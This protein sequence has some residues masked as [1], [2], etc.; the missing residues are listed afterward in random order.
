M[1]DT[2]SEVRAAFAQIPNAHVDEG[3]INGTYASV[4]VSEDQI[5]HFYRTV[6]QNG[7]DFE[8][9]RLGDRLV[10]H[11]PVEEEDRGLGE[12]FG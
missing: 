3:D 1:T 4:T 10:A 7:Y 8:A 9:K 12:L 6:R 5:G 11:V 2:I